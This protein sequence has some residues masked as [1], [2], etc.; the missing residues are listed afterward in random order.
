MLKAKKDTRC[1][2]ETNLPSDLTFERRLE[3]FHPF[4]QPMTNC[5]ND[6]LPHR[7]D[8]ERLPQVGLP[9]RG[10]EAPGGSLGMAARIRTHAGR[11]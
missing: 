4:A 1:L 10:N 6:W 7:R 8:S 9:S 11:N 3:V 2:I 5:A